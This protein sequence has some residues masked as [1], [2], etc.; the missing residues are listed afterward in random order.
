MIA[1]A[2]RSIANQQ[3]CA[4]ADD[5]IVIDYRI[6]PR[7]LGADASSVDSAPIRDAAAV[8]ANPAVRARTAAAGRVASILAADFPLAAI[9]RLNPDLRG[10]PLV[11]VESPRTQ[12]RLDAANLECRFVSSEARA[13]GVRSGMTVARARSATAAS[14][15]VVVINRSHAAESSA[16][17]AML[18]AAWSL[19]P[20]VEAGTPGEVAVLLDGLGRLTRHARRDP[21]R[22]NGNI[23]ERSGGGETA[24][25]EEKLETELAL[26][27]QRRAARAGIEVAV[28]VASGKEVAHL[29]ARCG[30]VR[31]IAPGMEASFLEW[32]PLD[33]L[34]L[35][36]K[37]G[38]DGA[39]IELA[40]ARWGIRRLGDLARLD[41]RAVGNRLGARA[42]D[43][44]R[45]ARGERRVSIAAR[46]PAET[47]TETVELE[48]GVENLEAMGFVMR[49]ILDRLID[50]VAMR[51]LVAGDL[52]LTLELAD[53]RRHTRRVAVAGPTNEPR[54]LLALIL[55]DL[56]NSPPPAAV[57]AIRITV[58][59]RISNPAQSDMFA[60]PRPA[61][62]RMQT[63]IARLAAM[64]GPDRVGT[65]AA[66][67][68]YFP[69]AVQIGAFAPPAA[70]SAPPA[71]NGADAGDAINPPRIA[72]LTLRAIRPPRIIEVMCDRDEPRYV[73]GDNLGARVVSFAGPW[74][75]TGEW[76]RGADSNDLPETPASAPNQRHRG[77]TRDYYDL[78]LDD[79]G[80]YR[81]FRD[82]AADDWHIDGIYD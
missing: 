5:S 28:G 82:L 26:E 63:V 60:P 10:R 64:Y 9:L 58:A 14:G 55:L 72:R 19:S 23:S 3:L 39:E 75:I 56:E 37:G 77:C 49:A 80:V 69:D 18:D 17:E 36:A 68:S 27:L 70:S 61:P 12:G 35:G 50:R 6:S 4:A 41:I 2:H 51:G 13:L 73:R 76:W 81:A 25:T 31:V 46:P 1:G 67:D 62:E 79:G 74:R 45:I 48:W 54:P 65:L 29:A 57:E 15:G 59:P 43:L 42:V 22:G 34:D 30:G 32:I 38:R 47:F 78:A 8:S 16:A 21:S 33:L 24:E 20:V 71:P 40:L 7:P 53:H 44:I 52:T 66:R 11:I